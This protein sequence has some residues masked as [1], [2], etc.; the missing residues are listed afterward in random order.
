MIESLEVFESRHFT[1]EKIAD[2]VFAVFHRTGGWA[3][4]NSGIVDLGEFSLVFDTFISVQAANDLRQ[5]AEQLTGK[6]VEAVINSHYHND[7]IWGNQVF[8]KQAKIISSIA[9]RELIETEGQAEYEW[10]KNN[11]A[12]QIEELSAQFVS[13]ND[14]EKRAHISTTIS[15]YEGLVETLPLLKVRLPN[16]TFEDRLSIYGSE[17]TAHL[18][19]FKEGHSP[20]DTILYLPA[21]GVLFMGDLLFIDFHPYLAD[22]DP[23]NLLTILKELEEYDVQSFIPGH[24]RI[25]SKK[26]ILQEREYILHCQLTTKSLIEEG[27]TEKDL[28]YLSVPREFSGWHFPQ[29]YTANLRHFFQKYA[30][31]PK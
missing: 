10:Y 7:H 30:N 29:Y 5:V 27:R 23:I 4:S 6:P 17:K 11:S 1:I 16:L 19:A 14:E 8:D 26:D 12:S 9:T 3:I 15:Y 2:G 28:Q 31:A 22:G 24:G 20:N 21:E 25:G 18:I 13:T